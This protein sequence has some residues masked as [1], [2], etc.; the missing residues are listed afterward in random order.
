[1]N[2]SSLASS[3]AIS[4]VKICFGNIEN[5]CD[6]ICS[7][8]FSIF[9]SEI[10]GIVDLGLFVLYVFGF[11]KGLYLDLGCIDNEKVCRFGDLGCWVVDFVCWLEFFRR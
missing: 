9:C 11:S 2:S 10:F 7:E 4:A 8:I 5:R 3:F 1:M 6:I